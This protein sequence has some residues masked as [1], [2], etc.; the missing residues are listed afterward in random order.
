MY[1]F[2]LVSF[3]KRATAPYKTLVSMGKLENMECLKLNI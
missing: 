2:L 3:G 1:M